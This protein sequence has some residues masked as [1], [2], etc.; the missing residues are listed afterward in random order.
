MR[1]AGTFESMNKDERRMVL[2]ITLP[3]AFRQ[4]PGPGLNVKQTL[5]GCLQATLFAWPKCCNDCCYVRIA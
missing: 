4:E 5:S 1:L 2:R 3:M